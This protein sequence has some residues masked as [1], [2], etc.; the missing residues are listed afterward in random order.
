MSIK[1]A[2]TKADG[3]RDYV[4]REAASRVKGHASARNK[5]VET[6]Y[7]NERCVKVDGSVIFQQGSRKGR[8]AD[9]YAAPFSD[10]EVP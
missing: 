8:E 4:L 9:K 3:R 10:L 6:K 2:K 5:S 1:P 7:G